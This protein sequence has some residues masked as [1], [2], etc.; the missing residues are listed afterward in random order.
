MQNADMDTNVRTG[1]GPT[2]HLADPALDFDT[3]D[4]IALVGKLR[5]R[6]ARVQDAAASAQTINGVSSNDDTRSALSSVFAHAAMAWRTLIVEGAMVVVAPSVA[7]MAAKIAKR[8]MRPPKGIRHLRRHAH[9]AVLDHLRVQC[10]I[11]LA[12]AR[13]C[14]V[15][16]SSRQAP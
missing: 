14:V 12:I 11:T 10:E 5:A 4:A 16:S 7:T 9:G 3:L 8:Y 13:R 2:D 1:I 6:L 15:R